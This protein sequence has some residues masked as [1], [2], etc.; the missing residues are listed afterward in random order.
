VSYSRT[1]ATEY[2][3]GEHATLLA[4]LSVGSY[5]DPTGI[6]GVLDRAFRALGVAQGDLAT[7]TV[8]DADVDK[9]EAALDYHV[10]LRLS[11]EAAPRVSIKKS[12][13]SSTV[14]VAKEGQQLPEHI[15]GLLADAEKRCTNLGVDLAGA[16]FEWGS[17]NLDFLEPDCE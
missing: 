2:V 13:G 17:F 1:D 10:L 7:A 5:D 11:R 8:D 14:T 9:L 16:S 12:M 4:E 6:K 3:A 15:K